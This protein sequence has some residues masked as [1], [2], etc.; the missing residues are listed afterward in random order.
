MTYPV[1]VK[2]FTYEVDMRNSVMHL[3]DNMGYK[4]RQYST[5]IQ[6]DFVFRIKGVTLEP[7]N[8]TK[9]SVTSQDNPDQKGNEIE[10][11]LYV[12]TAL[13]PINK[14]GEFAIRTNIEWRKKDSE[15]KTDIKTKY[16]FDLTFTRK[17]YKNYKLTLLTTQE[18]ETYGGSTPTPGA[19]PDQISAARRPETI[20]TYRMDLQAKPVKNVVISGNLM[21]IKQESATISKMGFSLIADLPLLNI[22]VKSFFSKQSRELVGLPTQTQ[23]VSETSLSYRFRQITFL[24]TYNFNRENLLNQK[25]SY[26][27]IYGKVS[28]SFSIL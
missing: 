25:Y 6:N 16:T 9:L 13:P 23:L 5:E 24:L 26:S 18:K 10:N 27:E 17:F 8:Q 14:V 11:N 21:L 4:N 22:P 15:G 12:R 1:P 3:S 28:R 7:K 19:N 2:S 20:S